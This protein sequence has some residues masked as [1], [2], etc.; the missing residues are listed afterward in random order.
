MTRLYVKRFVSTVVQCGRCNNTFAKKARNHRYCDQCRYPQ[1]KPNVVQLSTSTTGAI[2]EL[3]VA[4][5]L[6]AAGWQVF[7]ALSPS[8]YCDLIAV[9]DGK[10]R[11][12]EARTARYT[13]GGVL[14]YP[15]NH[16]RDATEFAVFTPDDGKITYIP[17][18]I[19]HEDL[20]REME[21]WPDAI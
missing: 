1:R 18:L 10:V 2:S 8:C 7:R 4:S 19:G 13:V 21:T 20:K 5:D 16:H 14:S 15:K 3:R 6:M 17:I 12:I 9:K 11:H